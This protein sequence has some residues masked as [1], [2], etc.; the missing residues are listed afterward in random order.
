MGGR[1]SFLIWA[2]IGDPIYLSKYESIDVVSGSGV[3]IAGDI[4]LTLWDGGLL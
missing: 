1:E 3:G 2:K 4:S